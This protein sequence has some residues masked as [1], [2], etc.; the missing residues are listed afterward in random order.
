MEEVHH[1]D[2]VREL[3]ARM[4]KNQKWLANQLGITPQTV[5]G[6]LETKNIGPKRI[7]VLEELFGVDFV[8]ELDR[9]RMGIKHRDQLD[10]LK[11][12]ASNEVLE[13]N[14]SPE[15]ELF[16]DRLEGLLEAYDSLT[17]EQ[18]EQALRKKKE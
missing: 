4:A 7:K 17:P 8:Y 14:N 11:L 6:M 9:K 2:L 10:I 3:L 18:K 5:S 12:E 15:V 1:G 16:L 13:K